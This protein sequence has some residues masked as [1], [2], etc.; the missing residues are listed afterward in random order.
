MKNT[1][2]AIATAP[3]ESALAILRVSGPEAFDVVNAISSVDLS[4]AMGNTIVHGTILD[5]GEAVDDVLFLIFR[6][7]HSYTGEDLI[8]ISCHGSP[9]ISRRI[10]TLLLGAGARMAERGEFT[11]RAF[12]NGKMDLAQAESVNDLIRARDEINAASAMHGL[13][14]SVQRVLA[15]L[16]ESLSQ[17]LAQIEVNIDYP[18]YDDV[19]QLVREELLPETK[20]WL[21][22]V[23]QVIAAAEQAVHVRAGIDTAIIGRPNVGKSSLL[24]AL[25]EEDKAIVTSV[26]GTTRDLVEGSV[27][28]GSLTLNLIDTAG[29]HESQDEIEK[30]GIEK[31]MQAVAKADLV[32]VVLDASA[33]ITPE[34]EKILEATKNKNRILVYNK[35][36]ARSIPGTLSISA[37]HKDIQPLIQAIEDFYKDG[38]RL[39]KEDTLNNERQIGLARQAR[40][41]VATAAEELAAGATPDLVT[42]DL[43]EAWE[44][45]REITGE[46]GREALL[47]EVFSRFCL[48]K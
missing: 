5:Q 2:A 31:S 28:I 16:V 10:L 32:L 47:D 46:G 24:N 14:G 21:A 39:A 6:R 18:E 19:H 30:I 4:K 13:K 15:P 26:A 1:I 3:M 40:A 34:D 43:Q 17:I 23:D 12:L 8:E 33:G 20:K 44:D 38:I 36:D 27:R 7:P 45:L 37:L 35:K 9:Y 42:M 41:A 22:E 11:E 48:G 25:L 29:L